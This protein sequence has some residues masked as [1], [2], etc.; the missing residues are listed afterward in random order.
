MGYVSRSP[1]KR[2]KQMLIAGIIFGGLFSFLG[3]YIVT[4]T[5]RLYD[6]GFSVINLILLITPLIIFILL[7]LLIPKIL[8]KL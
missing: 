1:T 2:E 8:K 7:L 4:T 3:S 5:F 6:Y